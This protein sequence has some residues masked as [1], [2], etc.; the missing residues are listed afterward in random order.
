MPQRI[1]SLTNMI[2]VNSFGP[3]IEITCCICGPIATRGPIRHDGRRLT[4]MSRLLD[5]AIVRFH[6]CKVDAD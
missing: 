2:E 1:L 5:S 4:A 3:W 6:V